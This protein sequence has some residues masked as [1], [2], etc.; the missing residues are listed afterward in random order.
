MNLKDNESFVRPSIINNDL[1]M[2]L[3]KFPKLTP[4]NHLFKGDHNWNLELILCDMCVKMTN[5][6]YQHL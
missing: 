3:V 2:I 4:F 1:M 5:F 6:D